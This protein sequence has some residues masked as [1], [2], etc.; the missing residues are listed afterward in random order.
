MPVF[1]AS[2]EKEKDGC[3]SSL[4]VN[5]FCEN[6]V[7]NVYRKKTFT[8]VYTDFKSFIPEAY[9]IGLITILVFQFVL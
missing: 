8:Q 7:E 4:D 3:L 2:I 6:E 9:K 5:I 1:W